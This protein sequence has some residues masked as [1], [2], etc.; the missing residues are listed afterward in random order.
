[1]QIHIILGDLVPGLAGLL[2]IFGAYRQIPLKEP[3]FTVCQQKESAINAETFAGGDGGQ[4]NGKH[5]LQIN[6]GLEDKSE[7]VQKSYFEGFVIKETYQ[8]LDLRLLSLIFA[9]NECKNWGHRVVAL[10]E[11]SQVMLE[12]IA[13][14][15][16]FE[17]T[18][19]P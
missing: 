14:A 16:F 8:G 17:D 6:R 1:V 9:V 18:S 5:L 7:F 4:R 10:P 11:K 12:I 13:V 2:L 3:C 15:A 19:L